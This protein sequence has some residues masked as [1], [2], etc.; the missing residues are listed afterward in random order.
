MLDAFSDKY[1]TCIMYNILISAEFLRAAYAE[2]SL[3]QWRTEFSNKKVVDYPTCFYKEIIQMTEKSWY[4]EGGDK[5][6]CVRDDVLRVWLKK[7]FTKYH[8]L[9]KSE[10]IS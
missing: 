1:Y 10:F 8:F 2:K 5:G 3:K 7:G 9:L 6:W 4:H